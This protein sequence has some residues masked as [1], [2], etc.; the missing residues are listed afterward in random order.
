MMKIQRILRSS[1]LSGALLASAAAQ[2]ADG[3]PTRLLRFAD[4]YKDSV[5]FVYAGDIYI[6]PVAGGTATRLTSDEGLELFPKFSPDGQ[7]IAFSGEYG[8]NRQVYVMNRDGSG[9]RQLSFY[10][11]VGKMPPR[12][13]FDYRVL[14]WTP[15]GQHV[16]VRA[17]RLP[18]GPRMG[19]PML[20]PVDGGMAKPLPV[21]EGGGGMLSPDGRTL[22]YTPIDR[23]W[24]TWK[25][26]KGGRAQD[27]WTYDLAENK[28]TRL[29]D[30]VGTDQ[31]PVWV[32]DQILFAS[33]RTGTLNLY[34]Y[35][36]DGEPVQVTFHDQFDLL[37]PSAG[38]EA[39]VYENGGYLY[40]FDP[41]ANQTR[42]LDI[43]VAGDRPY[44]Q[45]KYRS[46]AKFVESF[47]LS[48][49][50]KR[51]VFAAR[52]ELFT[53]PQKQGP[54]RNISQSPAAREISASWS[55][56]GK[57]VLYLSDV[58][59]EYELYMRRQDGRSAA[60]PLTS[61]SA[62]WRFPPVWAGSSDKIAW[63]DKNQTL[64]FKTLKGEPVKVDR[65]RFDD[66]QHYRFSADGRYLSYVK[67]AQNGLP[68]IYLY[69]T[70]QAKAQL[71]SDGRTAD[72][73]PVFDP[74]GRYLYFLSNRDHN[75]TFSDYEFDYLY[76]K[77][78]RIYAVALNDSVQL[79]GRLLSDEVM[80][81]PVSEAA[82]RSAEVN[83]DAAMMSRAVALAAP[84]S[85]YEQLSAVADGVLVLA[86]SNGARTLQL[87]TLGAEAKAVT[88]ADKV[89]DYRVAAGGK[90]LLLKQGDDYAIVA[91]AADQ[92]PA[93]N[94]L[95]LD[96][97]MMRVDPAI[98]WAQMYTDA[99][100]IFRDWFYDPNM[101]GQDWQA[102]HDRYQPLVAHVAHRYDLD[103]LL[104]E[105]GGEM[106]SGHIYVQ[107]GDQPAP[108]RV[109]GGLLGAEIVAHPSGNF[110]IRKIYRGENWHARFRSPLT[111]PGVDV[112]EGEFIIAVNGV[113]ASAVANF[114]QLMENT[115][116][117]VTTLT[118]AKSADGKQS[119]EVLVKPIKSE[120]DLRYLNWVAERAAYVDRL[121][122]GRIGYVHLPNTHVDG[123]RELFKQF[124]PQI[125]KE[126]LIIDDRYNGGGF[127]P[128][129]MIAMLAR[130][131]LN[132]WKRRGAEPNATPFYSHTGPKV[133]LVNG[134]SSSGGDALPYYFRKRGLGK[135]IGTR[136]W[137]GLIGISGNPSLADGGQVI[138]ATF[139]FLDTDGNWAVE[140]EGVAPDIEVIDRPELIFK[141]QDP[142]IERAVQ[143]LLK[144]LPQTPAAP[145]KAPAAPSDFSMQ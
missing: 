92:K 81:E 42:Q 70:E 14:D 59:G 26:Y 112:H 16:L 87:V 37:W 46:V 57:Y 76:N 7:Q 40:R 74:Q 58:S 2:A 135:I 109:E 64:W 20:V 68:Q 97:L 11:D 144:Q 54:T 65:G 132:Y 69:D 56:D 131:P 72:F 49:D 28:S 83:I 66:I 86:G 134:Y 52:G 33:D 93:D 138:A 139:R 96:N 36:A 60:I 9:L 41:K 89:N 133:M 102:I 12:G 75:L 104:S 100:R 113:P 29:T 71:L 6:A 23:E 120:T 24:R 143:E 18:W 114:Y 130:E 63:A 129:H 91:V 80:Q 62:I 137:G 98:E 119:R 118:V 136:T 126:A 128:E 77:A 105:I 111:E 15:D 145:I 82:P 17:N 141:G 51:A 1:L 95:A 117:K 115:A 106:N 84:A 30:Y 61:G 121:S 48:P 110:L 38:P 67:I 50:G 127:I 39:V 124:L 32:G 4:I 101:H 27:V 22:V 140:N 108:A 44:R 125:T 99:W 116:D 47:D 73:A 55:P 8:G 3:E 34:R 21:P 78:T 103:Y 31:Q 19:R 85:N 107:S 35:Q 13:G 10:N 43:R 94:R 5:T 53:V 123:N 45:A 122:N 79:P 142:S 90:Q 25:R 88:V